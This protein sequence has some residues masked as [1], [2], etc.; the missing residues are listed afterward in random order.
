MQR[1]TPQ[2]RLKNTSLRNGEKI[3]G[4]ILLRRILGQNK[5]DLRRDA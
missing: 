1:A 4:W 5:A 3:R 2:N